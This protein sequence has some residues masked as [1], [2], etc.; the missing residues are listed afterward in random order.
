MQHFGIKVIRFE[1]RAVFEAR[2][3]VLERIRGEFGWWRVLDE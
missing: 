3:K 2:S 1:N